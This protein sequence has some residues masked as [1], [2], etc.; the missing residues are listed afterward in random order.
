[1]KSATRFTDNARQARSYR[2]GRILLAADAA[3]VHSPFGGQGFNLGIGDAVNLGWK[4]A[5]TIRGWAPEGLLDSYTTERH[6]IGATYIARQLSGVLHRY[7]LGGE[8]ALAGYGAP[9]LQLA[10]GTRL[11]QHCA[12]GRALLLDLADSAELRAL[13]AGWGDRVN[14]LTVKPVSHPELTGLLVRPDGHVAW[15]AED[16]QL[17]SSG[18]HCRPGSAARAAARWRARSPVNPRSGAAACRN[19]RYRADMSIAGAP[20]RAAGPMPGTAALW[21]R[22]AGAGSLGRERQRG[23][24]MSWQAGM[25]LAGAGVALAVLTAGCS[26]PR[27]AAAERA[28]ATA[29]RARVLGRESNGG[30]VRVHMARPVSGAIA[31]RRGCGFV[32]ARANHRRGLH[33]ARTVGGRSGFVA[34]RTADRAEARHARGAARGAARDP[35]HQHL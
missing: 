15:A 28:A 22:P 27:D 25:R 14:V 10:D 3:H 17:G 20:D 32:V 34:A 16:G 21:A 8:H 33:A 7:D 2:L 5:A 18:G 24:A 13:A 30:R 4:L 9:D 29:V 26:A 23:G 12:D 35:A 6:P 11:A 31:G 19:L 1:V